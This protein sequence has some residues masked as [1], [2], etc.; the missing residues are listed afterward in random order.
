MSVSS[1][2][3]RRN[4]FTRHFTHGVTHLLRYVEE[5]LGAYETHRKA[6]SQRIFSLSQTR[7]CSHIDMLH[8]GPD[9]LPSGAEE[10]PSVD[11]VSV[12]FGLEADEVLCAVE[13]V[14]YAYELHDA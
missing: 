12:E 6:M 10:K 13:G 14:V 1:D 9:K 11:G 8:G 3:K 5:L 4:R 2:G 7:R